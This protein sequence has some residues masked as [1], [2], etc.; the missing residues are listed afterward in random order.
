MCVEP[1]F[2]RNQ[3]KTDFWGA[4]KTY[5][6]TLFVQYTV[7]KLSFVEGA[8]SFFHLTVFGTHKHLQAINM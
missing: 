1:L 7:K 3:N 2:S 5:F 8:L 6:T 4:L